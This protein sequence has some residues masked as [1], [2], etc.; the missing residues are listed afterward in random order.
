MS[1]LE[2]LV[3]RTRPA[4]G[5]ATRPRVGYVGADVPRELVA[6]AGL[7]AAPAARPGRRRPRAEAILGP[8]RRPA[9]AAHP[10]GPARRGAPLDFLL[11][12][13]DSD[14]SCASHLAARARRAA[15]RSSGSSTC[16]TCRPRRPRP[17]TSTGSRAR[18]RARA[19]VGAAADRREP[20]RGN[21]AA[22]TGRAALLAQLAE[23]R[24]GS[25]P[26]SPDGGARGDRRRPRAAGRR[27]QPPAG[28]LLDESHRPVAARRRVYL[29]GSEPRLARPLPR[30]RERGLARRRR[31][32]RWGEALADG[33]VDE[34]GD[35]LAALAARYHSG[36]APAPPR[37]DRARRARAREAA[38]AGADLVLAWIR[39]GDDAFAWGLPALR[40]ALDA[41]HPA[42][43]GEQRGRAPR[44]LQGSQPA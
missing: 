37:D 3:A 9:G 25:P 13:H 18:R 11:L 36:S 31:G 1:A 44:A 12:S 19:L 2:A 4:G 42:R 32:P 34:E 30:A 8:R 23:L 14:S 5:S 16:S 24:R 27:V 41:G 26:R 20:A 38:A 39:T 17:T 21:R 6:A 40:R 43:R 22:P 28:G 29:T 35:P 33:L 10:R 7:A 15:C